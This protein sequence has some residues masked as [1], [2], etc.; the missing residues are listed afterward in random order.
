MNQDEHQF[1]TF[2]LAKT[3][4][5]AP[6]VAGTADKTMKSEFKKAA[7]GLDQKKMEYTQAKDTLAKVE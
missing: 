2:G 7:G 5:D 1:S 6:K 4:A 3:N